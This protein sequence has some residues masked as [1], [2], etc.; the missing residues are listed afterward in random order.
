MKR[1]VLLNLK[2]LLV[3]VIL[4]GLPLLIMFVAAQTAGI[5]GC[6]MSGGSMP[7]GFCGTLYAILMVVGWSSIAIL[8]IT[9]GGLGLYLLGV[10]LF[11]GVS[12]LSAALRRQPMSPTV[13]G[14]GVS[15]MASILLVALVGGGAVTAVW[16]QT[17]YVNRCEGLPEIAATGRGNGPLALAVEVPAATPVESR[18]ILVVSPDGQLLFQMD[19][20]FRGRSPSWSPDGRQLAFAAQEWSATS[21]DLRLADLQGNVEAVILADLNGLDDISWSPDGERLLFSA[22]SPELSSELYFVNAD[23]RDFIRLTNAAGLDQDAR[24]SPDGRQIVFAS[25][26]NGDSDIYLMDIDGS[27]ERR[28]T[29]HSADDANPVWSPD[30]RWILFLSNRGDNFWQTAPYN[31]YIMAA[32]GGSQ[33][34]L[35]QSQN[36]VWR[37][38]WSPDGQWIAY[39]SWMSDEIHLVRPNGQDSRRLS[40]PVEVESIFSLDWGSAQ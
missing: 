9:V 21:P 26:R 38:V 6:Q 1:G 11:F 40:L 36:M 33:C 16:Y 17:E 8:P 22:V 31:L 24:I 7:G 3:L 15:A 32:D 23:G 34:Q 13:K 14:M 25:R 12:L 4:V 5:L 18:T 20:L 28:L 39:V 37:A 27:N 30:G 2:I 10:I 29:R 19:K 35:T